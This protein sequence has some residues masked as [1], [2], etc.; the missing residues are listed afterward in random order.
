VTLDPL[1]G[2]APLVLDWT[3]DSGA[4]ITDAPLGLELA[5]RVLVTRPRMVGDGVDVDRVV[6]T[7]R[8]ITVP[9]HVHGPTRA[10]YLAKRR[11]LQDIVAARRSVR[12][13]HTEDDGE[14]LS[15]DGWYVGGMDGGGVDS[16]GDSWSSYAVVLR[17]GD[18][19]WRMSQRTEPWRLDEAADWFP[20]PDLVLRSSLITARRTVANPGNVDSW[21]LWTVTG[22]G[23]RLDIKHWGTGRRIE[24]SLPIATGQVVR[25][26]TRPGSR[27][28]TDAAGVNLMPAIATDPEFWPLQGGGN[29]IELTMP[30]AS[31][32]SDVSLTWVPL[33][34]SV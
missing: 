19:F 18:P 16:D 17:C 24:Y 23:N 31:D 34:E 2:T 27:S 28:V 4:F 33:R 11:R 10:D 1:D 6:V 26:D 32:D 30:A 13:V 20:F 14:Q 8:D 7:E 5:P 21:P 9:L 22:P 25:I 12:V 15:I 3:A 29:D